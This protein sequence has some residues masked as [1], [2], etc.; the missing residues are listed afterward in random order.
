MSLPA[1]EIVQVLAASHATLSRGDAD[2][3]ERLLRPVLAQADAPAKAYHL[4]GLIRS[5]Q[6]RWEEAEASMRRALQMTPGDHECWNSYASLF[7]RAKRHE[8][9][10]P[11]YRKAIASN[12]RY[13]PARQNLANALLALGRADDAEREAREL[14]TLADTPQARA[15]LGSA[16]RE[17][18]EF[19]QAFAE[20]E[21]A[22]SQAPGNLAIR[23]DRAI[24][25]DKLGRCDEAVRE[26]RQLHQAGLRSHSLFSNWAGALLDSG[27]LE[28]AEAVLREAIAGDP[29][30]PIFQDNLARLRWIKTGQADF[31]DEFRRA[32]AA[33]PDDV[34]LRMGCADLLR[35]A[36][37]REASAAMIREGL[38]R[39]PEHPL[40]LSALGVLLFEMDEPEEAERILKRA[41]PSLKENWAQRENL[42]SVL[43]RL[44]KP[45]EALSHIDDALAVRPHDQAFLAHHAT[46]L[47]MLGDSGFVQLYDFNRMVRAYDLPTPPGFSSLSEFNAILCE[48]LRSLHVLSA[49]PIDQSLVN[50]TQTSKGLL[51]S[52][53]PVIRAFLGSV[54]VVM[55]DFARA[56]PEEPRHPFWGRRSASGRVKLIGCWSVRLRQGGYHVN[57]I[58][59]EGWISSAYYAVVPEEAR[60]A[61]DHQGWIQ[62]GEPRWPIPGVSA[63][64]FVEPRAGKLVLFPS[65]MW[66]GTVPFTQGEERMTIAM[67][68][69]PAP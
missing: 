62:F 34:A 12:P 20:F 31:A 26:Y 47:G 41:L 18:G 16:L 2:G 46:A 5:A 32:L 63:G 21:R 4:L 8:E 7:V 39:S 43:L 65:Y 45:E 3:A 64:H 6:A 14:L 49:H 28:E 10:V 48:R 22:L 52:R 37:Q 68:A 51:E 59:P 27:Q 57:H 23:H 33:R 53:D 13:A 56:M 55:Q 58:H 40:L 15:A 42:V 66:H 36:D 11:L 60:G 30:D 1:S 38:A 61:N 50:G 19:E 24:V 9:A 25:L 54:E 35:R 69:V 29:A 44:N 17:Q 67:D